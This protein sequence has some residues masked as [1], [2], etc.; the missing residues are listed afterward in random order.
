MRLRIAVGIA[1]FT[2][3]LGVPTI[4]SAQ[5]WIASQLKGTVLYYDRGRWQEVTPGQ[6]FGRGDLLR[7]LQAG[8]LVLSRPR[9]RIVVEPATAV[10]FSS[11]AVT[12]LVQYAGHIELTATGSRLNLNA[13]GLDADLAAG[14]V[15]SSV[16]R[17]HS[18]L[19]VFSG[20]VSVRGAGRRAALRLGQGQGYDSMLGATIPQAPAASSSSNGNAAMPS[21]AVSP[22]NVI[23]SDGSSASGASQGPSNNGN[24]NGNGGAGDH[25]GNGNN[26]NHGNGRG[27]SG[28]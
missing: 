10:A 15:S 3:V 28:K 8:S 20:S 16:D 6:G 26:G 14:R 1:L 18:T 21:N 13:P 27:K 7:T 5:D 22:S 17:Q 2:Y 12:S 4:A 9:A 23:P 24:G 25:G 19:T 11:G